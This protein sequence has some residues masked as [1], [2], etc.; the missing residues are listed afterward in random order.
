M[1]LAGPHTRRCSKVNSIK[2]FSVWVPSCKKI[3]FR[4]YWTSWIIHSWGYFLTQQRQFFN[5]TN[6]KIKKLS[7]L[8]QKIS[9][10]KK[11]YVDKPATSWT[12]V[13]RH[14]CSKNIFIYS[15]ILKIYKKDLLVT[16]LFKIQRKNNWLLRMFCAHLFR[17]FGS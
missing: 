13:S 15:Y 10:T 5:F 9:S 6:F 7:L 11:I 3:Y 12:E 16:A 4:E 17:V 8:C 2:S 14:L 1:G